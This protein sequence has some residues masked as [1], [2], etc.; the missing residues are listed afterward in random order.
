MPIIQAQTVISTALSQILNDDATS[1]QSNSDLNFGLS[2]LIYLLD[3]LGLDPQTS[4]GLQELI[5]T[6]T[7]GDQKITI[8]A[9]ISTTITSVSTVATATTA[10]PHYRAVGDRVTIAGA[11]Q[12]EYNGAYTIVSVPSSTTFTYNFAGSLTSPATG[13][14]TTAGDINAQMPPRL[15]TS[16][17]QRLA[18][19]DIPLIFGASWEEYTMQVNKT[20]QGFS[21]KSFYMPQDTMIGTLYLWPASNGSELHLFARTDAVLNYSS[22]ALATNLQLANG[23]EKVIIDI[24]A[25]ELLDSYNVPEPAYSRLKNKGNQSL[26]IFKRMNTR[27]NTLGMPRGVAGGLRSQFTS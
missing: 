7:L 20:A 2:T 8:A 22:M 3:F 17:F 21:V 18:G 4:I 1:T 27:I 15:E 25:A 11:T 26:R 12:T 16:S 14:I 23:V 5:F 10:T 13:T 19:M 6:P 24:L 9:G